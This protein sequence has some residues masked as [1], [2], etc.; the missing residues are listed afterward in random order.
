MAY[1]SDIEGYERNL[2][3]YEIE[4]E[5]ERQVSNEF[6]YKIIV[7]SCEIERLAGEGSGG[8]GGIKSR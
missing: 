4:L 8:S 2:K 5:R 3:D 6:A 1:A 7:L